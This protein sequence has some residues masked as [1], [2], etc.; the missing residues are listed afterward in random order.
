VDV[1]DR[2]R[3]GIA[4]EAFDYDDPARDEE[5]VN[6]SGGGTTT[7]SPSPQPRP[8]PTPSPAPSPPPTPRPTPP[9]APTPQPNPGPLLEAGGPVAGPVPLMPDGSCPAAYPVKQA[10]AC[11]P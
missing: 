6:V 4:C 9:P 5:P 3:E 10:A 8:I 7:P 2:E 1:L 11:Y